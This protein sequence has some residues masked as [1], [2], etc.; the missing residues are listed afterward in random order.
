MNW[1]SNLLSPFRGVLVWL[2]LGVVAAVE[3]YRRGRRSAKDGA[4]IEDLEAYRATRKRIDDA[5]VLDDPAAARDWLRD[6]DPRQ[7]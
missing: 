7:R 6:R 1:L 2:A 4:K 5:K 3:F